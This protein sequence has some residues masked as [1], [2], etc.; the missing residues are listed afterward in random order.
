MGWLVSRELGILA[1]IFIEIRKAQPR[2]PARQL[3]LLRNPPSRQTT[4]T[5][6]ILFL[7]SSTDRTRPRLFIEWVPVA[8]Q[9]IAHRYTFVRSLDIFL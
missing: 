7:P 4:T 2:A 6:K 9:Y 1:D 8:W 3:T 5:Q